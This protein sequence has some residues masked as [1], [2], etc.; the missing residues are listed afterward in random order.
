MKINQIRTAQSRLPKKLFEYSEYENL[1]DDL[2][3]LESKSHTKVCAGIYGEHNLVVIHGGQYVKFGK[4]IPNK[5]KIRA[6]KDLPDLVFNKVDGKQ[7]RD[8]NAYFG[9]SIEVIKIIETINKNWL[10]IKVVDHDA[11]ITSVVTW[12]FDNNMEQSIMQI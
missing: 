5:K 6:K 4:L 8:M 12:D 3:V 2:L 7:I 10:Q 11:G 1:I 9:D